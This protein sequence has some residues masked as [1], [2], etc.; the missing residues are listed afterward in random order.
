MLQKER[1]TIVNLRSTYSLS[2]YSSL[3]EHTKVFKS[4]GASIL[5]KEEATKNKQKK[6]RKEN[7]E[8]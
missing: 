6:K 3:S 1:R 4:S 5:R 2:R 8:K 7:E